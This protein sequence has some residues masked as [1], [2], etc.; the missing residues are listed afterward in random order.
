MVNVAASHL[1]WCQV[2]V[3][4]ARGWVPCTSIYFGIEMVQID[5]KTK[6][7][8]KHLSIVINHCLKTSTVYVFPNLHKK[9]N[10]HTTTRSAA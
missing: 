10:T 8:I 7:G 9:Y 5:F 6:T 2:S 1:E 3:V 4:T